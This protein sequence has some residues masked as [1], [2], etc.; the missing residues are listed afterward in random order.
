M[1]LDDFS[2]FLVGWINGKFVVFFSDESLVT[3]A[4]RSLTLACQ[5]ILIIKQKI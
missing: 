2:V 1:T 5:M 3:L 4:N